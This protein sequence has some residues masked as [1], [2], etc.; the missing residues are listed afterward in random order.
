MKIK[1]IY[2]LS[3]IVMLYCLSTI[4]VF[5]A[6]CN[7]WPKSS[8]YSGRYFDLFQTMINSVPGP[9]EDIGPF[10]DKEYYEE[11]DYGRKLIVAYF[12][13]SSWFYISDISN[14]LYVPNAICVVLQQR[15]EKKIYYYEDRCFFLFEEKKGFDTE[16]LDQLKA[17]NDW[18]KPLVLEE[19]SSRLYGDVYAGMRGMLNNHTARSCIDEVFNNKSIRKVPVTQDATGKILYAVSVEEN[20]IPKSYFVIYH[21]VYKLDPEKN[22]MAVTHWDFGEE[23]HEFKIQNGWDFTHC[24]GT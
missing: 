20:D 19:C 9:I 4:I 3:R 8:A 24:P 16:R 7:K 15:D 21:P 10:M 23:L 6:G 11:D 14:D 5:T 22:V 17:I 2:Y 1:S 13:W 18:N 12:K